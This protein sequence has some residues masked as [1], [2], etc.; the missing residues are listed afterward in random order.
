M[1][2][3]LLVLCALAPE[4]WALRGGD[5]ANA[6]GG[7]PVLA[8]TGMGPARAGRTLSTLL[9]AAPQGYSA[10][11][12]TGFCAAAAPG[13]RPGEVI[14]ADRVHSA[15]GCSTAT[16]LPD[17]LAQAVTGLG[18]PVRTGPL[19][20]ADHVVRGHERRVLH[21]RGTIAVDMESAAAFDALPAGLPVAA[22]RVV[23]D[24]PERELL[25]PGTLP[26]GLRAY[27]TLRALVP[28]LL[29]WHRSVVGAG[30]QRPCPIPEPSDFS[31]ATHSSL[32]TLP[33]E[34]S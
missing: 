28:A 1:S 27:R 15:S 3:P 16:Q 20:S 6:L 34:A 33:Q 32:P 18:L 17:V 22:V 7:S 10:V 2:A 4:E 14:V 25:R 26:G 24:T 8:R 29:G 21:R 30:A 31:L 9:A 19:Y 5:W 12:M 13:T 23:V 11:L